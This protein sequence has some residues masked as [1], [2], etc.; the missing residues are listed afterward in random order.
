[1]ELL[2]LDKTKS[3]NIN[4]SNN[5]KKS[6]KEKVLERIISKIKDGTVPW[7]SP[8]ISYPKSNCFNHLKLKKKAWKYQGYFYKGV[9]NHLLLANLDEDFFMTF[10]QI[11]Q[12]GASVKKGSKSQTVVFFMT[13]TSSWIKDGVKKNIDKVNEEALRKYFTEK[14]IKY[15]KKGTMNLNKKQIGVL[16][17]LFRD[18]DYEFSERLYKEAT[19]IKMGKSLTV[20][21]YFNVFKLGDVEG[22]DENKIEYIKELF[23]KFKV[24][25]IEEIDKFIKSVGVQIKVGGNSRFYHPESD[26]IQVPE[27]E[28]FDDINRYYSTLFHEI[29]HSTGHRDR[30]NRKLVY[31]EMDSESYSKE[32]L[33]A[34]IGS[35]M[36]LSYF[37]LKIPEYNYSYI[38][39]WLKAIEGDNNILYE[40]MK[41]VDRILK[42]LGVE[43]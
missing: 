40:S 24:K 11:R 12:L 16:S 19:M 1:M 18:I 30:L 39:G 32:E 20:L 37:G 23:P 22:L 3:G 43:I 8:N 9:I 21:R 5:K 15:L 27:I 10:N 38:D 31:Y 33:I 36:L 13:I 29:C 25:P 7:L 34:E 42:Y 28:K 2:Q 41:E 14:E 35:S 26:Y 17:E 4:K 6:A